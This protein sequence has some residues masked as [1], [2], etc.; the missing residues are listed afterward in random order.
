MGIRE[1]SMK[2]IERGEGGVG[3]GEEAAKGLK[4]LFTKLD[5]LLKNAPGPFTALELQQRGTKWF[6]KNKGHQHQEIEIVY[7]FDSFLQDQSLVDQL[8]ILIVNEMKMLR[9]ALNI[10]GK[11]SASVDQFK[12]HDAA[13]SV[14]NKLQEVIAKAKGQLEEYDSFAEALDEEE[15][16]MASVSFSG[17]GLRGR[18]GESNDDEAGDEAGGAEGEH[19][20]GSNMSRFIHDVTARLTGR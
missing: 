15:P 13:E 11:L 17:R 18:H 2:T 10:Q 14:G 12:A 5:E 1:L 4:K 20:G 7:G 9:Q 3:T 6:K 8:P 16:R 19:S